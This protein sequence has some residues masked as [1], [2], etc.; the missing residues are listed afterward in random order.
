MPFCHMN[1]VRSV[2]SILSTILDGSSVEHEPDIERPD[3]VVPAE[4]V[5]YPWHPITANRYRYA[6]PHVILSAARAVRHPRRAGRL[7]GRYGGGC[8]HPPQPGKPGDMPV[9]RQIIKSAISCPKPN[10]SPRRGCDHP[11]AKG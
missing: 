7:P 3:G 6:P 1:A 10:V 2:M 4:N 9:I 11:W 5:P 8:L